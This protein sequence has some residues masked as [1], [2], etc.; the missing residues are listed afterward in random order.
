MNAVASSRTTFQASELS[1]S[2]VEVFAA[3]AD[4][5]VQITRRDG[6]SL[7][8]MSSCA[9]RDRTALLEL[10]ARHAHER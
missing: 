7:V 1:R 5:P 4:H 8:L 3:A 2:S 6:E 10:A 9:D